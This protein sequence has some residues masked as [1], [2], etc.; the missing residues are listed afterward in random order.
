MSAK[1]LLRPAIGL[2]IAVLVVAVLLRYV[3]GLAA[4]IFTTR[5]SAL[6]ALM[7]LVTYAFGWRQ[8]LAWWLPFTL[9]A[10]S[11]PLPSLLTTTLALPLQLRASAMGATLNLHRTVSPGW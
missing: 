8:V 9:L 5:V 10:L 7:G 6:L 3:S 11:I 2:G 1:K 4:E